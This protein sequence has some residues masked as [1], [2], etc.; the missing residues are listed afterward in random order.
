MGLGEVFETVG[1]FDQSVEDPQVLEE[2]SF[3]DRCAE[4]F[5][6]DA[7]E[8]NRENHE[9]EQVAQTLD[10][11]E[12]DILAF[13]ETVQSVAP[14]GRTDYVLEF[15]DGFQD[16]EAFFTV[17]IN[18]NS[19]VIIEAFIPAIFDR[20]I[21]L[22]LLYNDNLKSEHIDG[23]LDLIES[24]NPYLLSENDYFADSSVFYDLRMLM[25][26]PSFNRSHAQR[27][28]EMAVEYDMKDL[29]IAF[30]EFA[31]RDIFDDS[32]V[33][34]MN[35]ILDHFHDDEVRFRV[36][37]LAANF[38][39]A[40]FMDF[41][42]N[43]DASDDF[44]FYYLENIEYQG[45]FS[46]ESAVVRNYF[47]DNISALFDY[48]MSRSYELASLLIMKIPSSVIAEFIYCTRSI[49]KDENM[50]RLLF[51]NRSGTPYV[52]ED[53]V[54]TLSFE[55]V[56][57]ILGD[58]DYTSSQRL[59]L[60]LNL[61]DDLKERLLNEF[62]FMHENVAGWQSGL[63]SVLYGVEDA[64]PVFTFIIRNLS[65][66]FLSQFSLP[67]GNISD[68]QRILGR[69]F[70]MNEVAHVD[71]EAVES[72]IDD[73]SEYRER[74]GN[75]SI[76]SGRNV[77]EFNSSEVWVGD[78]SRF[79]LPELQDAIAEQGP[80]S[81]FHYEFEADLNTYEDL[82]VL[83]DDGTLIEGRVSRG[84]DENVTFI[85]NHILDAPP[86]LTCTFNGHGHPTA[87]SLENAM[88]NVADIVRIL[89]ERYERYGDVV[90]EDIYILPMCF[91][92][93]IVNNVITE[94]N[95]LNLPAPV[96]L[97]YAEYNQISFDEPHLALRY[98]NVFTRELVQKENA[99]I[100]DFMDLDFD[101]N[102][103]LSNPT[104]I[105]PKQD[106]GTIQISQN[107]IELPDQRA[108]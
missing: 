108:V 86:P 54:E 37:S 5:G 48:N 58:D 42:R 33:D 4:V 84:P 95:N 30:L 20:D 78:I 40:R 23:I 10:Q 69:Y 72:A 65:A 102:F 57:D 6:P 46:Y 89:A 39:F 34:F 105:V 28:V 76:Y 93:N 73:I 61:A 96:F 104:V 91:G 8:S 62:P 70:V 88:F 100:G 67:Q 15:Y 75:I 53:F 13:A 79:N 103:N 26:R 83:A 68:W 92:N 85:R 44:V 82:S 98:G 14:A 55:D 2:L 31:Q 90:S 59:R 43:Q 21:F 74:F 3:E 11:L 87:V 7:F 47:E 12:P 80:A 60:V 49:E 52:V 25:S 101:R 45:G 17:L 1:D 56:L 18:T 38:S 51:N 29:V 36:V 16:K 94:L 19:D 24:E 64:D 97:T 9:A 41:I 107:E 66:N 27:I 63:N 71:P 81:Y 50:I 77:V 99:T 35:M 32:N 106:G 22:R